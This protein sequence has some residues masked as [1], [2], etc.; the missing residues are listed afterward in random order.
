MKNIRRPQ[1]RLRA[2]RI[3][4]FSALLVIA[5]TSPVKTAYDSVP[6]TDFSK[7]HTYAWV[8]PNLMTG[9]DALAASYISAQDDGRVRTAV[10]AVLDERGIQKAPRDSADVI[11][12]FTVT[13]ERRTQQRVEA[14]RST[15]YYPSYG[16]GTAYSSPAVS[17][18]SFTEGTLT[19][20]FFDRESQQLIW[21]GWGSK[22][23]SKKHE[24]P[25]RLKQAVEQILRKYPPPR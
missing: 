17:E 19:I 20:Q 4:V 6:G 7:Y 5:C 15:V 9:E 13:R 12:A 23:L 21:S 8:T 25:E 14:G 16:R 3:G 11:L 18:I 22:R 2:V 10:E 1:I 24:S